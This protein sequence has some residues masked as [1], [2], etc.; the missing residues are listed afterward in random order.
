MKTIYRTSP[1]SAY[2]SSAAAVFD[3]ELET[4]HIIASRTAY[5]AGVK[6]EHFYTQR[7][8]NGKFSLDR[9]VFD[10]LEK[11]RSAKA[12][13]CL[14]ALRTIINCNFKQLD[15][16]FKN[17]LK[18]LTSMD[19]TKSLVQMLHNFG[20]EIYKANPTIQYYAEK[21]NELIAANIQTIRHLYPDWVEFAY[22]KKLFVFPDFARSCIS[23]YNTYK[24][25]WN[26]MPYHTY[27]H[28]S[29]SYLTTHPLIGNLFYDDAK[30]L[31]TL[32]DMNGTTFIY[33]FATHQE[34]EDTRAALDAFA[35]KAQKIVVVVDAEN[36]DPIKLAGAMEGLRGNLRAKLVKLLLIND[37]NASSLWNQLA[38]FIDCPVEVL[39]M[40]RVVA[41]KSLSDVALTAAL[42]KEHF[43]NGVDSFLLASSDSDF[44]GL[45]RALPTAKFTML[46][47]RSKSSAAT[48]EA[49]AQENVGLVCLDDFNVGHAA[50]RLQWSGLKLLCQKYIQQ[51]MQEINV[52]SMIEYAMLNSRVSLNEAER[53]QFRRRANGLHVSI[54]AKGNLSLELAN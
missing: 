15:S 20:I 22:I 11:D 17:E 48:R 39:Q 51:R 47:E 21:V 42:C 41:H 6:E 36:S 5:L 13:R 14:T 54:D 25:H 28:I 3:S 35:E 7:S 26:Q 49:L 50:Y 40:E 32:Y 2:E 34:S 30:F 12:I 33:G 24:N 52:N 23:Y 37:V 45:V 53:A 10:E 43:V 44:T 16:A 38:D 4:S 46:M 29:E 19:L 18:N 1:L 9:A 31:E 27:L 8:E